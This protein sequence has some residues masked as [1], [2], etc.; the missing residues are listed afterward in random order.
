MPVNVMGRAAKRWVAAAFGLWFA[1]AATGVAPGAMVGMGAMTPMQG[2]TLGAEPTPVHCALGAGPH[3]PAGSHHNPERPPPGPCRQCPCA[4][5]APVVTLIATRLGE[6]PVAPVL[7][8]GAA[9]RARDVGRGSIGA[10]VVI[11]PALGPP[12]DRV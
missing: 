2:T 8:T 1:M 3:H 7:R 9:P 10:Q 5:C 4:C 6:V 11:P 12:Q